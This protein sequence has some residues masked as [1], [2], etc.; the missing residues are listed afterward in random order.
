MYW[1]ELMREEADQYRS[2]YKQDIT[3]EELKALIGREIRAEGTYINKSD[4]TL[5]QFGFEAL[6]VGY[7][8]E[9]IV[10]DKGEAY[11]YK[12]LTDEG[13]AHSIIKNLT[14]EMIDTEGSNENIHHM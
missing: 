4:G 3:E 6:I 13:M 1:K 10:D 9:V 7:D 5:R 8:K 2:E 14:W 12:L 11:R